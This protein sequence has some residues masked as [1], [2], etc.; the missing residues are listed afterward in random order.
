MIVDPNIPGIPV[1]PEKEISELR[2]LFF[3]IQSLLSIQKYL[4]S[5]KLSAIFKAVLFPPLKP[6]F[7]GSDSKKR[8]GLSGKE[9]GSD[10]SL[11]S[12]QEIEFSEDQRIMLEIELSVDPLSTTIVRKGIQK[13]VYM[14]VKQSSVSA[15][16]FQ[17]RII[18]QIFSFNVLNMF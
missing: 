3:T 9:R 2:L 11:M 10:S 5:L 12:S 7:S 15:Q 18:A 16:P 8:A 13:L 17:F 14:D 1:F 4:I 6:L